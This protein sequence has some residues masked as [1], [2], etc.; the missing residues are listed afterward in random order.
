MRT[1]TP[2]QAPLGNLDF[3]SS[4]APSARSRSPYTCEP[5][6]TIPGIRT[7]LGIPN[8]SHHALSSTPAPV[9]QNGEGV[10]TEIDEPE[11]PVPRLD[12]GD[13]FS[14]ET[15]TDVEQERKMP[16]NTHIPQLIDKQD[17][18]LFEAGVTQAMK[19]LDRLKSTFSR[20]PSS[21]EARVWME[22]IDKLKLQAK[23]KR[24]VVGVVGNTGAG[25]SSVI[26]AML[27]EERLVPTNCMRACTAV[28]TEL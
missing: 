28:V 12:P 8:V 21:D 18:G 26:N 3:H 10:K 13:I 6:G 20:Y 24:T 4:T 1:P 22:A 14:K 25:K 15:F 23:P 7:D 5:L 2:T 16:S 11:P 19:V 27:D 9:H 17:I